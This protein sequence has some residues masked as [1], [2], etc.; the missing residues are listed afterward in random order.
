MRHVLTLVDGRVVVVAAVLTTLS[1]LAGEVVRR[2]NGPAAAVV[3][4][5]LGS[6]LVVVLTLV[7][8]GIV[9]STASLAH[10]LTWWTR[11]WAALPALVGGDLGW[12]C[13]VALFIPAAAG[14]THLTGRPV[15]AAV[16]LVVLSIAIETLQATVLSGAGD[17]TD[18]VANAL[19]IAAGVTIALRSLRVARR[20]HVPLP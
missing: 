17:P 16:G 3:V 7:N 14:W 1:L 19:G 5:A 18:V 2:R 10:D 4:A 12:W 20:R 8:R 15:P 11:N 6:S 9:V 13:N